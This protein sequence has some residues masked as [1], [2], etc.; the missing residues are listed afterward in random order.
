MM[1]HSVFPYRWWMRHCWQRNFVH[2]DC[3]SCPYSMPN[4]PSILLAKLRFV[5]F[6]VELLLAV[7]W[8]SNGSDLT[9]MNLYCDCYLMT[10][11]M[12]VAIDV[13]WCDKMS[14]VVLL[15]ASLLAVFADMVAF[16]RA[17]ASAMR[18]HDP[19]TTELIVMTFLKLSRLDLLQINFC[20]LL[21]VSSSIIRIH[22]IPFDLLRMLPKIL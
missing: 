3:T 21:W 5:H 1:C 16:V 4:L 7:D 2:H 20:Y 14:L 13:L 17:L 18:N 19:V 22:F 15:P 11:P 8:A 10:T 6:S 12:M 9:V